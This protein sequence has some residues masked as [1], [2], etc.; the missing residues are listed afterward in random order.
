MSLDLVIVGGGPAG[1][2]AAA[3]ANQLGL[4]WLLLEASPAHANTIQR[5]QKGKHVMAEP[6]LVPLR[7]DL[8]FTAGT[9]EAVLGSWEQ[10]VTPF[11]AR[12]RYSSEVVS[13]SG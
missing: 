7:S 8:L 3:H 11:G 5:Y 9:R 13:I 12:M 4:N 6:A 10:G 2:S 1:L